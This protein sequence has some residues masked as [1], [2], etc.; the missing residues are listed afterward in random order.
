MLFVAQRKM[1]Q[2]PEGRCCV[3][4]CAQVL[5]IAVLVQQVAAA[6][7]VVLAMS[8]HAQL[9]YSVG[10]TLKFELPTSEVRHATLFHRQHAA[11]LLL[12]G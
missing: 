2:Q 11:W 1:L 8:P 6:Q 9:T 12:D 4:V 3:H 10:G 5:S 7:E